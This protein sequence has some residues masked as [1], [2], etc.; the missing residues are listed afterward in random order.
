M[1]TLGRKGKAILTPVATFK[2]DMR[3]ADRLKTTHIAIDQLLKI[4]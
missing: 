3:E 1:L 2:M 4:I